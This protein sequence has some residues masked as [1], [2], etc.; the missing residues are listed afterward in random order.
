LSLQ[1]FSLAQATAFRLQRQNL[2]KPAPRNALIRVVGAMCGVQAQVLSAAE[3]A[4][5]ARVRGLTHSELQ[6][7]LWEKRSLVKTYGPRGTLHLLPASELPLWMAALSA[8]SLLSKEPLFPEVSTMKAERL[9]AA[10]GAALADEPLTRAQLTE[11]VVARV[12]DWAREGMSS[13]W[14]LFLRP[15]AERGWLCFGPSQGSNVTF[16]RADQWIGSWQQHDPYEAMQE[17]CRRYFAAYGPA[18]VEYF[19]IWFGLRDKTTAKQIINSIKADLVEVKMDDRSVFVDREHM[20][21]S[22]LMPVDNLHLLPQY[23]CYVIG[24]VRRARLIPASGQVRIRSYGRGRYESATGVP[25]L[26]ID[27]VVCGMWEREQAKGNL[28][29]KVETFVKLSASQKSRVKAEAQRVADFFELDHTFV[30]GKL[31]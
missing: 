31:S 13:A 4:L 11:K 19:A 16:V 17:I 3:L 25:V 29:I 9:V 8:P 21:S 1:S 7:E 6:E 2:L 22:R 10:I 14:G 30:I 5:S 26:L 18:T 27:G 24:N 28:A 23:D 12:G 20:P 15:A